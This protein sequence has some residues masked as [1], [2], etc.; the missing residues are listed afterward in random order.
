[1]I[2][3]TPKSSTLRVQIFT[4]GF[5]DFLIYIFLSLP[6]S[7]PHSLFIYRYIHTY[8]HTH[9]HIYSLY[10]YKHTHSYMHIYSSHIY[11]NMKCLKK[12]TEWCS[13]LQDKE[14]YR[15]PE[16]VRGPPQWFFWS[17]LV[18]AHENKLLA[19][20]PNSTFSGIMLVA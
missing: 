16:T 4:Y 19:S 18:P 8:I 12:S 13:I 10:I 14:S 20:L 6:S 2:Y 3:A 15:I 17:W 7:P 5:M 1:M 9:M 11:L